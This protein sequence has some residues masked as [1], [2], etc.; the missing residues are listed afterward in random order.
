MS[1]VVAATTVIVKKHRSSGVFFDTREAP[2][3][4]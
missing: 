3:G 4:Y 2:D 1:H